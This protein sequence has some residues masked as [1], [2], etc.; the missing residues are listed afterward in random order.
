MPPT[1]GVWD[2][3]FPINFFYFN[4]RIVALQYRDGFLPYI[5]MNWP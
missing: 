1:L 3:F 2:L 5:N 4:W